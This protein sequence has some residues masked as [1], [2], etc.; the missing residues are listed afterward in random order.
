MCLILSLNIICKNIQLGVRG[1]YCEKKIIYLDAEGLKS[2]DKA[3]VTEAKTLTEL[4][5]VRA[6]TT[7]CTHFQYLNGLLG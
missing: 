2:Y 7:S 3:N 1:M 6:K 4:T 5:I